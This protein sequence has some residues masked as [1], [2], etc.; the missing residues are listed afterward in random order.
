M[1][2]F[3]FSVFTLK[4]YLD[5]G[6]KCSGSLL[7][8]SYCCAL[9][10]FYLVKRFVYFL[11][12]IVSL[13]LNVQGSFCY[14]KNNNSTKN[15]WYE[16]IP[17]CRSLM[18][19]F[20]QT[21]Y[22]TRNQIETWVE[23]FCKYMNMM[24]ISLQK[25]SKQR[26]LSATAEFTI[27]LQLKSFQHTWGRTQRCSENDFKFPGLPSICPKRPA[28]WD[29]GSR[30]RWECVHDGRAETNR[31]KISAGTHTYTDA[32]CACPL[33]SRGEPQNRKKRKWSRGEEN[34]TVLST[35]VWFC[36]L[37]HKRLVGWDHSRKTI[38][39]FSL[40]NVLL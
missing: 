34:K 8:F 4:Q 28:A 27:Q 23:V 37:R 25:H 2:Y 18:N 11:L 36:F 19:I 33:A 9:L 40:P 6:W 14:L 20:H 31:R 10:H 30:V 22:N 16:N 3:C 17:L 7:L 35:S 15:G 12:C 21:F 5:T 38:R 26:V 39:S 1:S 24:Q 29:P 32:Q 13:Y